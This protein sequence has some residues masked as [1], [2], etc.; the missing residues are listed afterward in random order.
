MLPPNV[1]RPAVPFGALPSAV[2]TPVP[3]PDTPVPI[4]R[5]VA[6]VSTAADGVPSAG[7]VSAGEVDSTTLPVPV[8]LVAPVPP[9]PTGS[10]PVTPVD[11]GKPVAFVRTPPVGVPSAPLKSTTPPDALGVAARAPATPVPSPATPVETGSPVALV[12]TPCDGEMPKLVGVTR[13]GGRG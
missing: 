3:R 4:G 8:A 13:S 1:T 12:S 10:V 2:P 11:S 5:P 6:F 7:V 9:L